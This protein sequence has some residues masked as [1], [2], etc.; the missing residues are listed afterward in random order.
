V[1]VV[2]G[3]SIMGGECSTMEEGDAKGCGGSHSPHSGHITLVMAI[4]AAHSKQAAW[5]KGRWMHEVF[6]FNSYEQAL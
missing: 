4:Y 5:V 3:E 1:C 6:V 2:E